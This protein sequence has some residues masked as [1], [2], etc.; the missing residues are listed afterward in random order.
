LNEVYAKLLGAH[1]LAT[2]RETWAVAPSLSNLRIIGLRLANDEGEVLFDVDVVRAQGQW[3]SDA[4]GETMLAHSQWGLNRKGRTREVLPWPKRGTAP[5]WLRFVTA[6][7]ALGSSAAA[8]G[9]YK[10]Y[11]VASNVAQ[12]AAG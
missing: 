2:A 1:I 4:W 9:L 8:L 10:D 6:P 7:R 12:L 5:R 3:A 11:V